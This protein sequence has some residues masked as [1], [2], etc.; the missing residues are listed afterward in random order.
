[1]DW[2]KAK[3]I[4]I[5]SLI[6]TNIFLAY[7]LFNLDRE[8]QVIVVEDKFIEDV[9]ELLAK[10]SI[11]VKTQVP[12][13]T[14]NL[15]IVSIEYEVYN[16]EKV[17]KKFLGEYEEKLENGQM[18]YKNENLAIRFEKNNKKL[19]YEDHSLIDSDKKAKLTQEEAISLAEDFIL[20]H[21]FNLKK[22]KLNFVTENDGIYELQYN[23]AIQD[24]IVEETE[25]NLTVSSQ[26]IHSFERYWI[27][28]IEEEKQTIKPT[29]ATKALLR[30]LVRDEYYGK[31]IN[32]IDI[33]YYFNMEDYKKD[34]NLENSTG[35]IAI[36]TWRISFDDGEKV[37]LKE[38]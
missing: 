7:V 21:G 17:L 29:S 1:M 34:S 38:N 30:L 4:L 20:D 19:I 2:S 3:N 13:K 37:F 35:G 26:G 28:N 16:T 14:P 36:P 18:I 10:Q 8:E 15:P 27:K 32:G 12:K 23:K 6:F 22:A 5:I 31:T 11:K 24:I 25:M 9:L 33:C